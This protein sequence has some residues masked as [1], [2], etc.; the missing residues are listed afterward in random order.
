M[1]V[2]A[3]PGDGQPTADEGG[4]LLLMELL[5]DHEEVIR[6]SSL[7][8]HVASTCTQSRP[9]ARAADAAAPTKRGWFNKVPGR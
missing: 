5:D 9:P 3:P 1:A 6:R 8:R 2:D 4:P 7:S